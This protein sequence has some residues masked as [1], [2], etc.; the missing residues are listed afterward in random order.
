M[1]SLQSI[2]PGLTP[3]PAD[4]T[5]IAKAASGI[6][7]LKSLSFDDLLERLAQDLVNFAI[8]L[9]IA[10]LVF[11]AGRFVIRKIYKIV[12]TIFLRRQ[13]DR[14][15]STFV[16]SLINNRVIAASD[17]V[18]TDSGAVL[19]TDTGRKKFLRAWQERKRDT[20]TRPYLKEKIS[21]GL[22]PY[23]QA[24]LLTRYLRDDLDAYPPFLWK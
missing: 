10:I 8:N 23:V 7:E 19:L 22:V 20:I 3:E 21:W 4:T 5:N 14:S 11:Y 12:S 17:L 1:I 16:L 13:I 18:R 9:A 2:L 6:K 15:L 24:L